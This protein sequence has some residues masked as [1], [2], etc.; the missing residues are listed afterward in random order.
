MD[1]ARELFGRYGV[2]KTTV[3]D[4]AQEADI[5]KGSIYLEFKTKQDI[6]MAIIEEFASEQTA[7]FQSTLDSAEPPYLECLKGMLQQHA[8]S[9][10]DR[11]N[12]Q[13]H[14]PEGLMHTSQKVRMEF[15]DHFK[16]FKRTINTFLD[17]A[18]ANGEL[19]RL[20]SYDPI[21]DIIMLGL[22]CLCPPYLRN[23]TISKT[24][25]PTRDQLEREASVLIPII[26]DG[27]TVRFPPD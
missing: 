16:F 18:A 23:I 12:S 8:L 11:A 2:E 17:K 4:I 27:I 15:V 3:E 7:F 21:S 1:A 5:G 26:I 9:V 22:S 10:Y 6:L 24:H 13:I 25:V 14:T 19:R 20:D